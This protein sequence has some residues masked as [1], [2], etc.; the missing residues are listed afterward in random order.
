MAGNQSVSVGFSWFSIFQREGYWDFQ[1]HTFSNDKAKTKAYKITLR[2]VK[3]H[4][5]KTFHTDHSKAKSPFTWK[6]R[7]QYKRNKTN[8][9][10]SVKQTHRLYENLR[11]TKDQG[12]RDLLQLV[13]IDLKR[14][15]ETHR[16]RER[17]RVRETE[18]FEWRKLFFFH[19]VLR[20]CQT[21][22]P[23]WSEKG[24]KKREKV[25]EGGGWRKE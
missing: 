15:E 11:Y 6:N 12:S 22:A 21:I 20:V 23:N 24:R 5:L 3:N 14:R 13:F 4:K 18:E 1:N 10:K 16:E 17:E 19:F 8:T 2:I 9:A 7:S 25:G